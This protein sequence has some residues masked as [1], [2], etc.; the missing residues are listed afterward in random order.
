MSWVEMQAQE[1]KS[2]RSPQFVFHLGAYGGRWR[3]EGCRCGHFLPS[4]T[5]ITSDSGDSVRG[6]GSSPVLVV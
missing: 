4:H 2:N 6:P 5:Q 3:Q 1:Q